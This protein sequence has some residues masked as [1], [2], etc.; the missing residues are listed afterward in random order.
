L[1][2]G[3]AEWAYNNCGDGSALK[4]RTNDKSWKWKEGKKAG[5]RVSLKR[6][7][8]KRIRDKTGKRV[9]T[10]SNRLNKISSILPI[11]PIPDKEFFGYLRLLPSLSVSREPSL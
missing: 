8:G 6:D 4:T 5:A 10:A 9:S 11:W 3:G 7:K 1:G 2:P